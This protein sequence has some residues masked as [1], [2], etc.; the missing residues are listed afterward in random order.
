M[1]SKLIKKRRF[2]ILVL[3]FFI[4]ILFSIAVYQQAEIERKNSIIRTITAQ[5]ESLRERLIKM[6][7]EVK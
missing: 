4:F 7:K 3:L 2:L 5:Y 6:E 1:D